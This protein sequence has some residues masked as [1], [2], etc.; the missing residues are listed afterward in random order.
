MKIKIKKIKKNIK[1]IE[2]TIEDFI[3]KVRFETERL[4]NE[5]TNNENE[6]M[7]EDSR[8]RRLSKLSEFPCDQ[9]GYKTPSK[10]LFKRYTESVHKVSCEQC[11]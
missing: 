3:K 11:D 2:P 10:T 5:K 7:I 6:S 8:E 1:R 4:E 9:C